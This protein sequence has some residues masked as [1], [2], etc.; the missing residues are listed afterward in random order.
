LKRVFDS[1]NLNFVSVF[2]FFHASFVSSSSSPVVHFNTAGWQLIKPSHQGMVLM[3]VRW[4]LR[5]LKGKEKVWMKY[6][7]SLTSNSLYS[8]I[9]LLPQ[10]DLLVLIS[11]RDWVN[12]RAMVWLEV[13][14]KFKKFS[15][16]KPMTFWLTA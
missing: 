2:H 1:F 14:G 11:V 16:L 7:T 6:S 9:R 3:P 13:L 8:T 4:G 10:K 5:H 12:P 15:V